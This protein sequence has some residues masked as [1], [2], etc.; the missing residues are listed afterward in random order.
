MSSSYK[1]EKD[2]RATGFK[3]AEGRQNEVNTR[4]LQEI[5]NDMLTTQG[6]NKQKFITKNMEN[7]KRAVE[8]YEKI[9]KVPGVMKVENPK[10]P[11]SKR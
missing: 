1:N 5:N 3:G 7:A 8:R 9:Q 11:Q 6:G 10:R 4:T 2:K